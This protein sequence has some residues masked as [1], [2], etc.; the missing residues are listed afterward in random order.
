MTLFIPDGF[1]LLAVRKS[2]RKKLLRRTETV[3][4]GCDGVAKFLLATWSLKENYRGFSVPI[5]YSG[6]G[7]QRFR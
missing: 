7:K 6:S 5:L 2:L 1:Q 4:K 3:L